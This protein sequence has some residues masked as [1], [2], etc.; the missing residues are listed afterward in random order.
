MPVHPVER[1]LAAIFAA[2][3][4]GYS[5]LMARDEVGTLARLKACRAIIDE[6]IASHRGRIFNTAGD[7]V[8]ADFAS[9]VDAVQCAVAVQ[10]AIAAENAGGARRRADAVPHRRP[11]RRCHGR[12]RQSARRRRQ[13]RRPVGSPR[14]ARCDLRLGCRRAITSATSCRWPSTISAISRSRTSRRRS[15][16][17][18]CMPETS[19][20][21]SRRRSAIARQAV[22]RG[23]AVPEHERRP[24]AGVFRRRHGRGDHHRAVADPLVLR[25]R[26]QQRPSPTRGTRSM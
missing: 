20:A 2:D 17:I 6:L 1:K 11:C 16:C 5:R 14:R 21:P 18:G 8:V 4:A 25:H 23:A 9:A 15:G 3:I 10:A 13:H 12:R 26:A 22:D 7:S 24:G 19:A